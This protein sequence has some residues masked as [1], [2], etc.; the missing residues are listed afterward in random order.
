MADLEIYTDKIADSARKLIRR[1]YDEARTRDHN[2]L[3]PEHVLLAIAA[4]EGELFD[5]VMQSL[6]LDP[7]IVRQS[8]E[9][10]F[11][12]R[13][14][15]GPGMAISIATRALLQN[16]LRLAHEGN[17]RK[18]ESRD[19][20]VAFF[21]DLNSYPATLLHRPDADVEMVIQKIQ[22]GD[23]TPGRGDAE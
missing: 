8:L 10:G 1:A 2:Q 16:A 3:A 17:R 23:G 12:E 19:L 9:T 4:V 21:K 22:A 6:K 13:D 15:P 18:I 14:Y 5:E 20:F 11:S 7:Q